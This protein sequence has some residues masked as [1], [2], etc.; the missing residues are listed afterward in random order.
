M[1]IL[2][3]FVLKVATNR[4]RAKIYETMWGKFKVAAALLLEMNNTRKWRFDFIICN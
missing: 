2:L 3:W 4:V 1:K